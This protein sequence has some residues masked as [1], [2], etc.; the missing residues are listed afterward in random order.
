MTVAGERQD[1]D[2]TS[3]DLTA[4][5]YGGEAQLGPLEKVYA[6]QLGKH[7]LLVLTVARSGASAVPAAGPALREHYS[8]LAAVERR[9]PAA[10]ASVLGH[11]HVGAWAARCLRR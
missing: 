7:K 1:A 11:P 3:A 5:V 8:L 6:G 9:S 10:V 2:L 4:L